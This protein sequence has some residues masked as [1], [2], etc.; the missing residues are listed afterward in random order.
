VAADAVDL[1]D[2]RGDLQT[3]SAFAAVYVDQRQGKE[4][5]GYANSVAGAADT[6]I[7]AAQRVQ[8]AET[9][10]NEILTRDPTGQEALVWYRYEVGGR[11]MTSGIQE[12]LW[13]GIK[14][15]TGTAVSRVI[16]LRADCAKDCSAARQSLR[17]FAE[18]LESL[19]S[20]EASASH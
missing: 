15:L 18:A 11:H 5:V 12:Q 20:S 17:G 8:V 7:V 3:V 2:Y 16:A 4:M 13:Y 10:F 6:A 19:Q 9:S 14:S 1:Q